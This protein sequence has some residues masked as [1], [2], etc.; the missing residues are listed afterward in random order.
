MNRVV[1]LGMEAQVNKPEGSCGAAG[2]AVVQP[3]AA[4]QLR[5]AVEQPGA[6]EQLVSACR[7]V[8]AEVAAK[9]H[10]SE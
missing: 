8:E 6:A 9:Q 2:G 7:Q 5:V 1:A 4:E 10:R 3:G